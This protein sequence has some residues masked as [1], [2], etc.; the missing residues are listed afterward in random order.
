MIS[1]QDS[2][3]KQLRTHL[4]SFTESEEYRIACAIMVATK[5]MASYGKGR[6]PQLIDPSH[7]NDYYMTAPPNH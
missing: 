1:R 2:K 4:F 6:K 3:K 7:Y 5:F